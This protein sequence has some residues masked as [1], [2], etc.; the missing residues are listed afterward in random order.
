MTRTCTG[1]DRRKQKIRTE[2]RNGIDYVEVS[3][4][5]RRWYITV[6]FF[7]APPQNITLQNVRIDGGRR[8]QGIR[9]TDIVPSEVSN[10]G[11]PASVQIYLDKPGDASTYML[12]LVEPDSNRPLSGLDTRYASIEFTFTTDCPSELDCVTDESCPRILPDEPS[13]N[14]LAKD[15]ASFRRLLLDRLA[16][17]MPDWQ[18]RHAPDLG[19]ALIEL[20]A[21]TGD[22]LSYYQ[23][24]VATEA[25]LETARRRISVRRHARLVDY[26]MHEGCNARAWVCIEAEAQQQ[27]LDFRRTETNVPP[28]FIAA[29]G[30]LNLPVPTIREEVLDNVPA[31]LY[32]VFEPVS[33]EQKTI[34]QA[35]NTIYFYTWGEQECCLPA[36]TTS[37]TLRDSSEPYTQGT[38]A[39][40][41]EVQQLPAEP[42]K[43]DIPAP[44]LAAAQPYLQLQEGDI[45]I[46][47]EVLGPKTGNPADADPTHRHA[48]RLTNATRGVDDLYGQPVIEIQW[49]GEDALPFALCLSSRSAAP[50]CKIYEHVSV[51]HGNVILVDHGRT[52][53]E[54]PFDAVQGINTPAACDDGCGEVEEDIPRPFHLRLSRTPLT[55]AQAADNGDAATRQTRQT[56]VHTALPQIVLN[57][58]T[59]ANPQGRAG[60]VRNT[61][62]ERQWYPKYD[63]L[64]SSREDRDFVVEIDDGGY[65]HLRF[66]DGDLGWMPPVGTLF[67]AR[68]RVGNGP[69]GNVGAETITRLAGLTEAGRITRV[70]NPLPAQGGSVPESVDEVKIWAP[71]A[72]RKR[73]ERAI[74]AADYLE[75]LTGYTGLQKAAA[76]LRWTGSWYEAQ[77]A[78]DPLGSEKASATLLHTVEQYLEPYRQMG[79]DLYVER[80]HYIPLDI[81][82]TICVQP[83]YLRGHVQVAL[84]NHF[85]NRMLPSGQRGY[86]HPDNMTFG[87]SLALSKLVAAAQSVVGVA[88][89]S[90]MQIIAQSQTYSWPGDTPAAVIPFGPFDI[91]Q[92][93]NDPSFPENGT[94]KLKL[95]GGR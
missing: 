66:G 52:V 12:R 68:Y 82:M 1:M 92:V 51:A 84:L 86:F 36:G 43:Q 80:A 94:F 44:V 27:I 41:L 55:F 89:V 50:E 81:S 22:Y 47:E 17:I 30:S 42:G 15:Y 38:S 7:T 11:Q 23:D 25:Y 21:Y 71:V 39:T 91:P 79:H 37:A 2:Q 73:R 34:Y 76:L 5:D 33:K 67:C 48:V 40:Q 59:Q 78:I 14:Y 75:L 3:R 70:W 45:L 85:S 24:A 26:Q 90:E 62:P 49:D 20:L 60:D 31:N 74:I 18:E 9:A 10:A 87:E 65:A 32:E 77:I 29:P 58:A 95:V 88:C 83:G 19:I 8:I 54:G 35:H 6:Y 57:T 69:V 28:Y 13:I 46:F 53:I 56:D 63:L 4:G 16:L 61:A 93:D 64:G 72:F